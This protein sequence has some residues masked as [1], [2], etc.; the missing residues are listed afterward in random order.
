[1]N[2]PS[3][4]PFDDG[5]ATGPCPP[6]VGTACEG[7]S[8]GEPPGAGE[9][10]PEGFGAWTSG[11]PG[12]GSSGVTT[13]TAL[14]VGWAAG[15]VAGAAAAV[16][17]GEAVELAGA[18]VWVAAGT[19]AVAVPEAAVAVGTIAVAVGATGV[20]VAGTAVC[21]GGTVVLVGGGGVF[22]GTLVAGP[23]VTESEPAVLPTL[24]SWPADPLLLPLSCW[25]ET[26]ACVE[27]D[28]PAVKFKV[29]SGQE[30][31]VHPAP[32]WN[33]WT[34][35]VPPTL[36][37][38]VDRLPPCTQPAASEALV[39]VTTD[40][41]YETVTSKPFSV[42]PE[43]RVT[44]T[45]AEIAPPGAALPLPTLMTVPGEAPEGAML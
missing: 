40:G 8:T 43:A 15:A 5:P 20:L 4:A 26:A 19:V 22:E 21:V 39:A 31:L 6:R 24:D 17:S 16:G 30:P 11:P 9:S 37:M 12:P 42:S 28:G 10:G 35:T 34:R 33:A 27:P 13:T 7:G 14:E 1:M 23:P 3:E 38:V 18:V 32:S 29:N 45:C 36:S 25:L 2:L 41:L 44:A